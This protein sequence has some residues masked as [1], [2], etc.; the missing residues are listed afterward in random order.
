M[1]DHQCRRIV[2]FAVQRIPNCCISVLQQHVRVRGAYD[3]PTLPIALVLTLALAL[4]GPIHPHPSPLAL[5]ISVVPY[6][7]RGH[8]AQHPNQAPDHP[9]HKPETRPLPL[10]GSLH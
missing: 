10:I 5:A 4:K 9:K 7:P 2:V 8:Y 6:T 1:R 3:A